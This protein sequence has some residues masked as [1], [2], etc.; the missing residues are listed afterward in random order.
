MP[1]YTRSLV[2]VR[3]ASGS[4]SSSCSAAAAV[5]ELTVLSTAVGNEIGVG[6][7]A[8]DKVTGGRSEADR[9]P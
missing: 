3:G 5:G 6:G 1:A 9:L 8:E 7:R 2:S 4:Q